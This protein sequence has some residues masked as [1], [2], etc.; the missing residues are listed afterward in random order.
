MKLIQAGNTTTNV[1][2]RE[3]HQ[4]V[5]HHNIFTPN[6]G[7]FPK[8]ATWW[9]FAFALF[10]RWKVSSPCSLLPRRGAPDLCLAS[11]PSCSL[12]YPANFVPTLERIKLKLHWCPFILG[13]FA[14]SRLSFVTSFSSTLIFIW[15]VKC[16]SVLCFNTLQIIFWP[17]SQNLVA[18]MLWTK[19]T[20]SQNPTKK[21]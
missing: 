12:H 16:S 19:V 21:I 4:S 6:S 20:C 2:H 7:I 18:T 10:R 14:S 5:W 9:T 11:H 8:M 17:K 15:G 3:Y 13:S 1:F